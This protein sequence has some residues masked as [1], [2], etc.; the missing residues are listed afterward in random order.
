MLNMS[1]LSCLFPKQIKQLDIE[2][3]KVLQ[4]QLGCNFTKF[5]LEA[6]IVFR[7]VEFSR[8][9]HI[10]ANFTMGMKQAY[11]QSCGPQQK[12]INKRET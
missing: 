11:T 5:Q 2:L 8:S 3:T 1:K 10:F 6:S 12:I 9:I 4:Q 7:R